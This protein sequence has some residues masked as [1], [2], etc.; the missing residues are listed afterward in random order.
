MSSYANETKPLDDLFHPAA[1]FSD[2]NECF[3]CF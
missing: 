3:F 1:L 2:Y